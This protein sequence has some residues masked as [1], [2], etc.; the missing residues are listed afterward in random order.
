METLNMVRVCDL[1]YILL[2]GSWKGVKKIMQ[3][4][5]W[6]SPLPIMKIWQCGSEMLL[7]PSFFFFS[8]KH[9]KTIPKLWWSLPVVHSPSSR[10]DNPLH[11]Q[12]A[13]PPAVVRLC[14]RMLTVFIRCLQPI[15]C[16]YTVCC[17]A[18]YRG[19][20]LAKQ[21]QKKN[22]CAGELPVGA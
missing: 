13:A 12:G 22:S 10:V 1:K 2:P 4:M 6:Y 21:F 5:M 20:R 16:A 15:L 9:W 3:K 19:P 7:L 14:S 18:E 11:T 8:L 17:S